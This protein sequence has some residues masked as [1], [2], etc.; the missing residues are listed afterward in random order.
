MG[1]KRNKIN[2]AT[3]NIILTTMML[4]INTKNNQYIKYKLKINNLL[5]SS[6]TTD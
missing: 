1:L 2:A 6:T 5:P 3:W 4:S